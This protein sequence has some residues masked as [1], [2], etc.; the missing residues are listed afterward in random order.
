MSFRDLPGKRRLVLMVPPEVYAR[1]LD[2]VRRSERS[3]SEVGS[4]ALAK[5]FG[6]KQNWAGKPTPKGANGSTPKPPKPLAAAS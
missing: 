2:E 4:E 6:I 5:A 3:R 1:V